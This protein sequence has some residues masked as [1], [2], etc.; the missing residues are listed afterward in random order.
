MK[1]LS[2]IVRLVVIIGRSM[3][4]ARNSRVSAPTLEASND[5][6]WLLSRDSWALPSGSP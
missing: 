5:Q 2:R 3:D 1:A 4:V 6:D